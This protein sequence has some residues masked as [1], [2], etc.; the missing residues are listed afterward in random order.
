MD[1]KKI[2]KTI[3]NV[4]IICDFYNAVIKDRKEKD[5]T[6]IFK[7]IDKAKTLYIYGMGTV[8]SAI[9][10]EIKRTFLT[11]GK[12]FY[13]FSG[14]AEAE[15][16]VNLVANKDLFVIISMSGE[17]KFILDFAKK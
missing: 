2:K 16:I 14:Y 10:K 12:V 3:N 13:D 4:E 6:E 15:A 7:V 1:N 8:K 17:N 5:C 9:K 11:A